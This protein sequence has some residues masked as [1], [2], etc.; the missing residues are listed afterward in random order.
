MGALPFVLVELG[1]G[2]SEDLTYLFFSSYRECK[3]F[4]F[5]FSQLPSKS[6]LGI[7]SGDTGSIAYYGLLH[8][9]S[10][11]SEFFYDLIPLNTMWT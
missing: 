5:A 2:T 4:L 8:C 7:V 3:K 1:G 9:F 6:Y 10:D 11:G